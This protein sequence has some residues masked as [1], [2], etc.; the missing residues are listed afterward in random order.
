M[1]TLEKILGCKLIGYEPWPFPTPSH[2]HG[3][4]ALPEVKWEHFFFPG[5]PYNYWQRITGW[6]KSGAE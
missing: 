6:Q 1:H 2:L 3:H 4:T 5:G